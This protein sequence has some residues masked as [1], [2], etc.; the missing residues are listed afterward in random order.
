MTNSEHAKHIIQTLRNTSDFE[1]TK[2]LLPAVL[3]AECDFTTKVTFEGTVANIYVEERSGETWDGDM[4][5]IRV[6]LK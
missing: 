3:S 4:N 1:T 6:D 5:L 2:M